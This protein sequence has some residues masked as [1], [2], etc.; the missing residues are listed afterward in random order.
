MLGMSQGSQRLQSCL[1]HRVGTAPTHPSQGWMSSAT[2][3]SEEKNPT[4]WHCASSLQDAPVSSSRKN[5]RLFL[6]SQMWSL[7]TSNL[8]TASPGKEGTSQ[9]TWS[10]WLCPRVVGMAVAWHHHTVAPAHGRGQK[11]P[12]GC[13]RVRSPHWSRRWCPCH[14][15]GTRTGT[16]SSGWRLPTWQTRCSCW[17]PVCCKESKG[18]EII[19][20]HWDLSSGG[21]CFPS[22]HQQKQNGVFKRVWLWG[23]A[24]FIRPNFTNE[25]KRCLIL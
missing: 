24:F 4:A 6:V 1:F 23:Q 3:I 16:R 18:K 5:K 8:N 2:S 19:E 7:Y 17:A 25:W 11:K 10:C 12:P 22:W 20:S 9:G 21:S 14:P 15:S 13:T